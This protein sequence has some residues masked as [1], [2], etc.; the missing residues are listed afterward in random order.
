MYKINMECPVVSQ[1][2]ELDKKPVEKSID[3]LCEEKEKMQHG[4]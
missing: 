2:A 1:L 4:A 3:G